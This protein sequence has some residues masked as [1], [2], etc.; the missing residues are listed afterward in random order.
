MENRLFFLQNIGYE[1]GL[2]AVIIIERIPLITADAII[3]H[4]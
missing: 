2:S 3:K 1:S 4:A